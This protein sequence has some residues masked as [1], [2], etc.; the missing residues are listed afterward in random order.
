MS[1]LPI[2]IWLN[3]PFSPPQSPYR[4]RDGTVCRGSVHKEK[5]LS[6]SAAVIWHRPRPAEVQLLFRGLSPKLWNG[7]HHHGRFR[8]ASGKIFAGPTS[9][10]F[11]ATR[12]SV[13]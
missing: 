11:G 10:A 13:H 7:A 5:N 6:V 9:A 1:L 12:A 3:I 8:V 4:V 2:M